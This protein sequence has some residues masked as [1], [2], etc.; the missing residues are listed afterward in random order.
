[1]KPRGRAGAD[2][3][4]PRSISRVEGAAA[5][6]RRLVDRATTPEGAP[7]GDPALPRGVR[8][9]GPPPPFA[10]MEG[11]L[12]ARLA[13]ADAALAF[14]RANERRLEE[15]NARLKARC[16]ELSMAV[17]EARTPANPTAGARK[18]PPRP[19]PAPPPP[20]PLGPAIG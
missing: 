14:A 3:F 4:P 8:R 13:D 10:A 16:A 7:L 12:E 2:D 15:E 5:R 6:F 18:P 1:M 19:P 20:F 11:S 17:L 9:V